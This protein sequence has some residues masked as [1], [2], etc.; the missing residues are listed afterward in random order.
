M[1]RTESITLIVI[2]VA[3]SFASALPFQLLNG[4]PSITT[5]SLTTLQI[6]QHVYGEEQDSEEEIYLEF[7]S[8]TIQQQPSNS[9]SNSS[10]NATNATATTTTTPQ[11]PQAAKGP[12]IPSEKGYLVQEIG[13]QLYS[14]SDG[15]YNAMFMVTDQGVVAID[16]PPTLGDKYLKAIAEITDKPV[17][18]V[19]YSH[20]HLDHIGAAG[21]YPQNATFIAQQETANELQRAM[22]IATNKSAVP[23][24]PTVTFPKNMTLQIGNQTLQLDYHGNNHLPGNIFIYA[25]NQRVLMLVDI[26]FPGWV[27]FAYLAIAKDTAGFIGAHDIALNNYDFNTIVAGHLTRLGTRADVEMQKEFVLDLERAAARANQNV[28]FMDIASQVGFDDPW[29]LFSKYIDTINIQ[30]EEEM[31]PKWENRLGGA[32]AFMS[33]HCI[34]M[35]QS[36]RVD[37]SVQALFQSIG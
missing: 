32:D 1:Q 3:S 29:L 14:V 31:L 19:I 15:S 37:P 8:S 13:N 35:T 28:S 26:I 5:P 4:L 12:A 7:I 24:V 11:I 30:C 9:S 27:P 34:A 36:G 2:I 22:N 10:D 23:P 18:H 16:A 25:P 20:A 17:S 6:F 21:I 33:T